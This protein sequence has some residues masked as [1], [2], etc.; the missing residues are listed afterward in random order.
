[1]DTD[2]LNVFR[3]VAELTSLS[4]AANDNQARPTRR[5]SANTGP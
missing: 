4:Q 3:T 5:Q 1:M 2:K